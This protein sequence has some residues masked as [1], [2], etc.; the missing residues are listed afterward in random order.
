SSDE[1]EIEEDSSSVTPLQIQLQPTPTSQQPQN[2]PIQLSPQQEKSIGNPQLITI[3]ERTM[4]LHFT[5][6]YFDL[7]ETMSTVKSKNE[8]VQLPNADLL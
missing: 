4:Q 8:Y 5:P 2:I 3:D 6:F 7:L 1:S